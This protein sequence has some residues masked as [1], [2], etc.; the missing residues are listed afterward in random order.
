MAAT[1][2]ACAALVAAPPERGIQLLFQQLLDERAH[3][4]A[5]RFLQRIEPIAP[6]EWGW[7][8]RPGWRSFRHGV[9]SLSNLPIGTYA[10]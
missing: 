6:G 8:C 10:V 3:L 5:H 2:G 7:R 9:G 4:A 1:V